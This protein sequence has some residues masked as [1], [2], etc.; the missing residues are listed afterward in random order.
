MELLK[1]LPKK[2]S[3]CSQIYGLGIREPGS[4]IR[5]KP[6][7]DPESGGQKGT[8]SR[9]W[10]RN[11]DSATRQIL[12]WAYRTLW[13]HR[14]LLP[15]CHSGSSFILSEEIAEN[16]TTRVGGHRGCQLGRDQVLTEINQRHQLPAGF[17]GWF[18]RKFGR[19]RKKSYQAL[20]VKQILFYMLYSYIRYSS[21][22][23][24]HTL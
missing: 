22:S 23:T 18:N 13:L 9:I 1:F 24:V 10:I 8:G 17:N 2:F 19:Q 12:V 16:W 21:N 20:L 11:T 3:I 4:G 6:I 5:K 15:S 7:P 14:F